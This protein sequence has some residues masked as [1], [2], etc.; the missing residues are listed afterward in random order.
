MSGPPFRLPA[1]VTYIWPPKI[2]MLCVPEPKVASRLPAWDGLSG[3]GAMIV[4][5]PVMAS[6]GALGVLANVCLPKVC[7]PSMLVA[8]KV[9]VR[10]RAAS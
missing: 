5:W 4:V 10:A 8:T 7:P 3:R 1:H 2:A 6:V 9:A